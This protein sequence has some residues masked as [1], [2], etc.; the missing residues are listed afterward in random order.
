MS[1]IDTQGARLLLSNRPELR[2]VVQAFGTHRRQSRVLAPRGPATG[3]AR[4]ISLHGPAR[5]GRAAEVEAGG[6]AKL[7]DGRRDEREDHRVLDLRQRDHG[8]AGDA[9]ARV[10]APLPLVP[11]LQV[12]EAQGGVLAAAAEAEAGDGEQAVHIVLLVL[13][14]V[15]LHRLDRFSVRSLV[16][17]AGSETWLI[18]MPWS[19][20]GRNAAGRRG[21]ARQGR[22]D[23]QID[24]Q[25]PAR[26]VDHVPD[27]PLIADVRGRRRG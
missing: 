2:L 7:D 13:K 27:A 22:H 21:T 12:D 1:A 17:P 16:A 8:A 26:L 4:A 25:I 3:R 24:H 23:Q 19:S 9:P 11:V 6:V 10:P 5:R 18:R 15:M 14:E 20:F